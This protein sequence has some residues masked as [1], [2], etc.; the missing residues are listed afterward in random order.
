[1]LPQLFEYVAQGPGADLFHR[2]EKPQNRVGVQMVAAADVKIKIRL[3]TPQCDQDAVQDHWV[4]SLGLVWI[5]H[6]LGHSIVARGL[7]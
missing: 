3:K 4:E 6:H 7:H 1:M 2:A 5:A